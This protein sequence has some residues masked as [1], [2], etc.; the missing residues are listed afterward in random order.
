VIKAIIFDIGGVLAEDVW[1]HLL[2]DDKV[3]VADCYHLDKQRAR[4]IGEHLWNV[5]AFRS[6]S[7]RENWESLEKEYWTAF[8]EES[9]ISACVND[10]VQMT[11]AFIKPVIGMLE[12]LERLQSE[13]FDLAICSNNTEFW[14]NRQ[15]EKLGLHKFFCPEKIILSCRTGALKSSRRYEMFQAVIDKLRVDKKECLFVDDRDE[16]IQRAVEFGVTG[17]LF[18]SH[19]DSRL[20]YLKLALEKEDLWH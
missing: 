3:G 6:V 2:L 7:N 10:L 16:N 11:D 13:R 1:E 12:L 17:I 20:N 14:F 18:P 19:S 5:F 9:E 8:I 15:M 4:K